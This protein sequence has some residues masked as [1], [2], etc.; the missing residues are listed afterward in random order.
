[1]LSGEKRRAG[2]EWKVEREGETNFI[3]SRM[4]LSNRTQLVHHAALVLDFRL[5]F[6]FLPFTSAALVCV[7]W[8]LATWPVT[9]RKDFEAS[10]SFETQQ[11][12]VLFLIS[13]VSPS[14]TCHWPASH[15]LP[16]LTLTLP[17]VVHKSKYSAY[18]SKFACIFFPFILAPCKIKIKCTIS[19]H[20]AAPHLDI[21]K[22][23][24]LMRQR[25]RERSGKKT[26]H[27][28]PSGAIGLSC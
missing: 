8:K 22:S 21:F 13:R 25:G 10:E 27:R 19:M 28:L 15:T 1:M 11:I 20:R 16:Q 14:L 6:P 17:L 26:C 5:F 23:E 4:E 24:L 2:T 9:K 3:S 18:Q 12:R 7:W